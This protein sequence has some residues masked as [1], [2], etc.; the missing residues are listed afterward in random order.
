MLDSS[1]ENAKPKRARR[2][3][4]DCLRDPKSLAC[5]SKKKAFNLS[6]DLSPIALGN[7]PVLSVSSSSSSH[8]RALTFAASCLRGSIASADSR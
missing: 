5:I 7:S 1:T 3:A 6:K 4:E 2:R 8:Q